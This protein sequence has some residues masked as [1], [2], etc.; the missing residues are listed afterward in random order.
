MS[1]G[2]TLV[3]GDEAW[4]L[5]GGGQTPGRTVEASPIPHPSI[6]WGSAGVQ[7]S[8]NQSNQSSSPETDRFICWGSVGLNFS[9]IQSNQSSNISSSETALSAGRGLEQ[10]R[11]GDSTWNPAVSLFTVAFSEEGVTGSI[12]YLF[13]FAT[14]KR[15]R[16]VGYQQSLIWPFHSKYQCIKTASLYSTQ[17]PAQLVF[18]FNN[19]YL[20]A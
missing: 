6:C 4:R 7:S 5:C 20:T 9:T 12:F 17:S 18:V 10:G 14:V 11:K 16:K 8:T 1:P 15:R 3:P 2:L 13:S 19:Q